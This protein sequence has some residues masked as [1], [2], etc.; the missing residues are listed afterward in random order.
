MPKFIFLF[1]LLSFNALA[2][3]T[4]V[5]DA[6]KKGINLSEKDKSILEIGEI[7]TTRYVIGGVLGTY[8]VGFGVGHAIQGRW[9][10]TGWIFTAGEAGSAAVFLVGA[11]GCINNELD[12]GFNGKNDC[13]GLNEALLVTGIIGFV[14]FRI[15][16]VVDVWSTPPSHNRKYNE[17]KDYIHKSQAKEIKTSLFL[18]PLYQPK[19]GQGLSLTLN[20]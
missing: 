6:Q 20:F 12:K 8:P 4:L 5:Y 9:S 14:G 13:T 19:M 15:W 3:S 2:D 17:L 1:L 7:S 16:E 10:D 11:L 18:S